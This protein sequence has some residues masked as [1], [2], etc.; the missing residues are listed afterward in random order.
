MGSLVRLT[1]P[2]GQKIFLFVSPTHS[3]HET[4]GIFYLHENHK[5]STI[6]IGKYTVRH[7]DAM[8]KWGIFFVGNV[9][10][11]MTESRGFNGFPP[12]RFSCPFGSSMSC[13]CQQR[14]FHIHSSGDLAASSLQKGLFFGVKFSFEFGSFLFQIC[15]FCVWREKIVVFLKLQHFLL[16]GLDS[17]L[18]FVEFSPLNLGKMKSFSHFEVYRFFSIGVVDSIHLP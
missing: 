9:L 15:V 10:R 7:M 17:R 11:P 3:I 1:K 14:R 18:F 16:V 8:G 13:V 12:L 4:N 2:I 6:Q 5:N